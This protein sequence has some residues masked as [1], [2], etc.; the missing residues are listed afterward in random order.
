MEGDW[1][2]SRHTGK[3]R[4]SRQTERWASIATD[5]A[6]SGSVTGKLRSA[7]KM[8]QQRSFQTPASETS[9]TS[10]LYPC[11]VTPEQCDGSYALQL[12][13]FRPTCVTCDNRA[14][15]WLLRPS[16]LNLQTDM[17]VCSTPLQHS[18]QH[19]LPH[20]QHHYRP[21]VLFNTIT[22]LI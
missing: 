2:V 20:S 4:V 1:Q 13:I 21:T 8:S 6:S 10:R 16:A 9:A 12:R 22:A 5:G 7:R 3:G 18:L 11:S 17:R 14:M 19:H 15:R